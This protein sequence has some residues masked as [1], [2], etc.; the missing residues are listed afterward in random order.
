M[1]YYFVK[2]F[3]VISISLHFFQISNANLINSNFKNSTL[4]NAN[5]NNP[6]LPSKTQ[7]RSNGNIRHQDAKNIHY[8]N[9]RIFIENQKSPSQPQALK[10]E[11]T[12][13]TNKN[14]LYFGTSLNLDK[15]SYSSN[16][17]GTSPKSVILENTILSA[18]EQII[19]LKDRENMQIPLEIKKI[20]IRQ[21]Q[22]IENVKNLTND[23]EKLNAS[24]QILSAGQQ[25]QELYQQTIKEREKLQQEKKLL[26]NEIQSHAIAITELE[27]EKSIIKNEILNLESEIKTK[28]SAQDTINS[29]ATNTSGYSLGGSIFAGYT[30]T[31]DML[32]ISGEVGFDLGKFNIGSNF[33]NEISARGSSSIFANTRVGYLFADKEI[34][35]YVGFGLKNQSV[36]LQYVNSIFNFKSSAKVKYFTLFLGAEKRISPQIGVFGEFAYNTA[37]NGISFKETRQELDFKVMQ[38]RVG[39]RYYIDENKVFNLF[40]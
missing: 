25:T 1:P 18:R 9:P 4:N 40:K 26:E 13:E 24:L 14:E 32:T 27:S 37:I 23:I 17:N 20:E 2:V 15:S 31:I 30:K 28:K 34:V 35:G 6:K 3:F 22:I 12:K 33:K 21:E 7:E 8:T 29:V 11:Y 16:A 10:G 36:S 19:K 5:S 38:V 39:I